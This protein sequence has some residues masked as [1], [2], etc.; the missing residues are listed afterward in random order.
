MAASAA[1]QRRR[2]RQQRRKR[3]NGVAMGGN[4]GEKCQREE[5]RR[6]INRDIGVA[7]RRQRRHH[8]LMA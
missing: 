6:G 2:Q 4:I 3:N 1:Y 5:E 8:Q 7:W